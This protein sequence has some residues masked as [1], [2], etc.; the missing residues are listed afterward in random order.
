MLLT[1]FCDEDDITRTRRLRD[2][3]VDNVAKAL[4]SLFAPWVIPDIIVDRSISL[5]DNIRPHF[6]AIASE[7]TE[8]QRYVLNLAKRQFE[9]AVLP[10]TF[11]NAVFGNESTVRGWIEDMTRVYTN[12]TGDDVSLEE[13]LTVLKEFLEIC[14]KRLSDLLKGN[15]MSLNVA[16]TYYQLTASLRSIDISANT[17]IKLLVNQTYD[18][19]LACIN[20][21]T[22]SFNRPLSCFWMTQRGVAD[23]LQSSSE[24]QRL[25]ENLETPIKY[26]QAFRL[27]TVIYFGLKIHD[28]LQSSI[29]P[30]YR[31]PRSER[32]EQPLRQVR[33]LF[34]G[35][36]IRLYEMK[37]KYENLSIPKYLDNYLQYA[38]KWCVIVPEEWD[39]D[40]EC[41]SN[42]C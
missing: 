21:M 8:N 16:Q 18:F 15:G 26:E 40:K 34:L 14:Q 5:P 4:E 1:S 24:L 6:T 38:E 29:L 30:I 36:V 33:K 22:S 37:D 11:H 7:L 17:P 9:G 23:V 27:A 31:L 42:S 32:D 25:I 28:G 39:P 19:A 35:N 2:N 20:D 10:W 3:N 13:G 41:E 12:E